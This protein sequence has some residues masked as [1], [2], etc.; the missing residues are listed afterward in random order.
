MTSCDYLEGIT[1]EVAKPLMSKTV[2]VFMKTGTLTTWLIGSVVLGAYG[3][4]RRLDML[5]LRRQEEADLRFLDGQ[6]ACLEAEGGII[7][8]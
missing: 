8:D 1:E 2:N 5:R 3:L 4:F 6:I 7:L